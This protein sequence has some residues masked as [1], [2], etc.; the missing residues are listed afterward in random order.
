M[1]LSWDTIYSKP[2]WQSTKHTKECHARAREQRIWKWIQNKTSNPVYYGFF[3]IFFDFSVHLFLVFRHMYFPHP[4]FFFHPIR[5]SLVIGK[6]RL[7]D[8]LEGCW[9]VILWSRCWVVSHE[10]GVRVCAHAKALTCYWW[11]SHT[12]ACWKIVYVRC[13]ETLVNHCFAVLLCSS[14]TMELC[15]GD[16]IFYYWWCAD[17]GWAAILWCH[18]ILF[19][20]YWKI[21]TIFN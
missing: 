3:F 11:R 1:Y 9:N 6:E 17:E 12:T 7:I 4:L 13:G 5:L 18:Y 14:V 19:W 8:G 21:R 2:D 20:L 16:S 15:G 10:C